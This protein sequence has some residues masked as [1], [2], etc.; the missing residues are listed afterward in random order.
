[1]ST[2]SPDDRRADFLTY[3]AVCRTCSGW[4][5]LADAD[6]ADTHPDLKRDA[7]RAAARAVER[8]SDFKLMRFGDIDL[9][10]CECSR[11]AKARTQEALAI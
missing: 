5:Y 2:I 9:T 4:Q 7:K 1:M 10:M 6:T 3:V 8:G 11:T